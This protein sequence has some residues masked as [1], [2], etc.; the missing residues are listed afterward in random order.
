M[1]TLLVALIGL[2]NENNETKNDDKEEDSNSDTLLNDN[3]DEV[4]VQKDDSDAQTSEPSNIVSS[5]NQEGDSLLLLRG[6]LF[7]T[8]LSLLIT[9]IYTRGR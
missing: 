6:L 2:I 3:L 9:F 5:D 1:K 4:D 7:I 8:F